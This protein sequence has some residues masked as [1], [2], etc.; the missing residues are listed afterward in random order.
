[1]EGRGLS[2]LFAVRVLGGEA[3]ANYSCIP[4]RDW[5]QLEKG[6]LVAWLH[7]P[8]VRRRIRLP[9]DPASRTQLSSPQAVARRV[10]PCSPRSVEGEP[11]R[12]DFAG[13]FG[14]IERPSRPVRILVQSSLWAMI[15]QGFVRP[16]CRPSA[17]LF[18]YHR[19]EIAP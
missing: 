2:A 18:V 17:L 12:A 4:T 3:R 15:L 16:S 8:W 6:I 14:T 13:F 19:W 10:S 1:M 7:H 9:R 11:R 5:Q